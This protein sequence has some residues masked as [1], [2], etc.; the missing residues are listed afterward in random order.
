MQ[1]I[2]LHTTIHTIIRCSLPT[3]IPFLHHQSCTQYCLSPSGTTSSLAYFP[4]KPIPPYL[5]QSPLSSQYI[6]QHYL[7]LISLPILVLNC[8]TVF[9]SQGIQN[10]VLSGLSTSLQCVPYSLSVFWILCVEVLKEPCH[11]WNCVIK[12]SS[13]LCLY[14]NQGLTGILCRSLYYFT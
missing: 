1:S 6:L 3:K 14:S 12:Y 11:V 4:Y 5:Y 8:S 13:Y 10:I 9:P 7:C 2:L